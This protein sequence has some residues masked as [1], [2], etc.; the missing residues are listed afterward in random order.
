VARTPQLNTRCRISNQFIAEYILIH[1]VTMDKN[2]N[3]AESMGAEGSG[4]D[5]EKPLLPDGP[6][7]AGI[8]GGHPRAVRKQEWFEVICGEEYC[9]FRATGRMA[10][11]PRQS[12]LASCKPQRKASPAVVGITEVARNARNQPVVFVVR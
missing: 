8:D 4:E 5:W 11:Y 2:K 10:K 9:W 1:L 3:N 12:A 7:T 6:I